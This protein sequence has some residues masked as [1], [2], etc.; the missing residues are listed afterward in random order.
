MHAEP[1]LAACYDAS[2]TPAVFKVDHASYCT[3]PWC[4]V[5]PCK[6]NRPDAAESV[7]F[8]SFGTLTYSYSTCGST[9]LLSEVLDNSGNLASCATGGGGAGGSDDPNAC[10][11]VTEETIDIYMP[12]PKHDVTVTVPPVPTDVS[13]Y[14]YA[15]NNAM[16]AIPE[17]CLHKFKDELGG[18]AS[19]FQDRQPGGPM[20][21][22]YMRV[23]NP[24][25]EY[26]LLERMGSS[27]CAAGLVIMM[28][29][30]SGFRWNPG[31]YSAMLSGMGYV[32]VGPDS[33]AMPANMGLKGAD[34]LKTTAEIDTS[35]YCGSMEVYNGRCGT[36]A[37]PYCYSTKDD[38]IL[39]NRLKYKQFVERSYLVR[40]LELDYFVE[41][42][43]AL[44]S[45]YN[46]V[47]LF[48]RSEGA[49][50]ASRYYHANLHPHLTSMIISGW[51]CE[52]NYFVSCAEHAHVCGNMCSK[53]IPILNVNGDLDAYFGAL[54]SV[55]SRVSANATHGYGAAKITGNC[56]GA[57]D[58]QGFRFGTVVS[59]P[60]A[61]HS[62]LYS[63]DNALR[64]LFADFMAHP[65]T[66]SEWHSLQRQGCTYLHGVY[67]CDALLGE[68]GENPCVSYK[69]NEKAEWHQVGSDS[70]Y[71]MTC[72]DIK[73]TYKE[74]QCCGAPDKL[75]EM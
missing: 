75:V 35:E 22:Y 67:E 12:Y 20:G 4:Y 46:K 13:K 18:P 3:Q 71:P 70:Q 16:V 74:N 26:S 7:A 68:S 73:K 53:E 27:G 33:H 11:D 49:M 62:I 65:K 25:A 44:L 48:G 51:S 59:L 72:G 50:V 58:M 43:Q 6:C 55:S 37:K 32:V 34:S 56:R 45:S 64:S 39:N 40:K 10:V 14:D 31:S 41:S 9:D 23:S 47:V 24:A 28:H 15:T 19:N 60:P 52:F 63:H 21:M 29:G 2:T 42:R 17:K 36:W 61:G 66:P 38:N 8:K 5:D 69:Q 1:G 54:D 57:L 30:T